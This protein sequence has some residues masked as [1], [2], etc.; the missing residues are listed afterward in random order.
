M[1]L[2]NYVDVCI[3]TSTLETILLDHGQVYN[4]HNCV[5][6]FVCVVLIVNNV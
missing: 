6:V 5:S 4:I 3:G 1:N 2:Y